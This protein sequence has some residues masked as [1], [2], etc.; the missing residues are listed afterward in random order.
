MAIGS[1]A[2]V[3]PPNPYKTLNI[4]IE[5]NGLKIQ[6]NCILKEFWKGDGQVK[7]TFPYHVKELVS[8]K[9]VHPGT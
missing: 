6:S 8:K 1:P 9:Q 7:F 5:L 4:E 2:Q 3:P